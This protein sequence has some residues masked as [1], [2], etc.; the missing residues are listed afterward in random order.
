[1]I[2]CLPITVKRNSKL[3]R[4]LLHF[5]ALFL[6]VAPALAQVYKWVDEKGVTHYGERPPQGS[7]PKGVPNRLASPL[8]ADSK[9]NEERQD[10][11]A[12]ELRLQTP[13]A[14]TKSP[15]GATMRNEQCN[16]QRALLRRLKESPGTFTRDAKGERVYADD[17]GRGPAI[18][19]QEKLVAERCPS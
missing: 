10:Q 5:F 15:Q 3:F 19:R 11:G 17:S 4:A 12:R 14:G 7:A 9:P 8:P 6:V 13:A 18:A 16:E 1:M 2:L